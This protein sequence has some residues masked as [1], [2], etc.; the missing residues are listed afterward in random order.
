[1]FY[2]EAKINI[3]AGDGGSGSVAFFYIK[4]SRKKKACGGIGG[5][6]GNVIFKPSGS[7]STLSYFHQKIHFKAEN[8]QPG[9][10]NNKYGRN[11]EDLI[12]HVPVG[13][14]IKDANGTLLYD[15]KSRNDYYVAQT[16]GIG[17]RGNASFVSQKNKY[18]AFAQKGEQ[19]KEIWV[20]LELRLLA[21]AALVG[22]PNAGKSTI[23][24]RISNAKPK[25]APYP[26]TTLVPN[27]GVVLMQDTSF[28]VADIPGLIEG[29][30]QG[31][32]LGDKFL[33]HISRAHIIVMVIDAFEAQGK[34]ENA[35]QAY[36]ILRDELRLYDDQLFEKEY[37]IALTKTDVVFEKEFIKKLTAK[38]QK[39]SKK[40]VVAISA[41]TGDGIDLFLDVLKNKVTQHREQAYL[42]DEQPQEVRK[43]YTLSKEDMES[44]KI[45]IIN[46][47]GEYVI[48]NKKLERMVSMTDLENDEA[49]NHLKFKLKK[50]G[51]GDKLKKMGIEEGSTVII[52]NL[53][54]ELV[55]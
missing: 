43:V 46:K 3:K 27:L 5:S 26:F 42:E 51:I 1:M 54:F 8:G 38:L 28:V 31:Q 29:A 36:Q 13:T 19:I 9:G 4:G 7:I 11:G 18:P 21:D 35:V 41:V 39:E 2:D 45:E 17:G 37:F 49:L 20:N 53:V 33:R 47:D 40:E 50:M 22:F 48:K 23:I 30:H 34:I 32:G 6:G 14:I 16:G 12:I 55:D 24:S 10:S 25:I 44:D 52:D 15:I